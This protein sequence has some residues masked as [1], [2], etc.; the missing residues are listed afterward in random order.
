MKELLDQS[1]WTAGGRS[2]MGASHVR[3]GVPNQDALRWWPPSAGAPKA[4]LAVADGH[5]AS[6]H[7]RSGV[8]AHIAVEAATEVLAE[9]LAEPG[10]IAAGDTAH[11][12]R[13]AARIVERW[14]QSVLDHVAVDP[15]DARSSRDPFLPY[16]STLIAA[17]ASPAGLALMQIGDGDLLLGL[18][19]GT[20]LRPLP[21]D[22]GMVGQQTYSL[23]QPSAQQRFRLHILPAPHDGAVDLVMLAT[24]GLS[25]SFPDQ[26]TLERIARPWRQAIAESGLE[27]L[28]DGLDQR[29]SEISAHGSGDDITLGLLVRTGVGPKTEGTSKSAS[30][31]ADASRL[32]APP[33]ASP[34]RSR[35]TGWTRVAMLTTTW[36]AIAT[37]AALIVASW[38]R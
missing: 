32:R 27:T 11:G 22:Q 10:W 6:V 19:D 9:A 28:S 16:G 30:T 34:P 37:V 3:T 38:A 13:L 31:A 14:R 15:L 23:C 21:D 36:F 20:F 2:V 8:G 4:V 35:M 17:A 18:S 7:F 26:E 33:V 24:D 1:T 5:G 25:K 12:R 29:L